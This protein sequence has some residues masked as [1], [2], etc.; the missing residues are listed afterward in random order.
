M[1]DKL[2]GLQRAI[3]QRLA[4]IFKLLSN[5]K[6]VWSLGHDYILVGVVLALA[7]FNA[8]V[9]KML[10][11]VSLPYSN[12]MRDPWLAAAFFFLVLMAFSLAIRSGSNPSRDSQAAE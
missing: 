1:L 7:A 9:N 5:F 6:R 8:G 4:A 12:H 10:A 3:A 2:R 11:D